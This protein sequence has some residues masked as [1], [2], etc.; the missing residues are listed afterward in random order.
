M[1]LRGIIP[2]IVTPMR[3]NE[4]VDLPRMCELIDRLLA[5][6]VHGIFVLGTT[7]EFY[8]LDAD[9]KRQV[10][11]TAVRHVNK[12][13]PVFAG[14][15]AETTRETVRITR[16]AEEEGADAVAVI[17][18]YFVQPSQAEMIDH[19][20][21]V[22]ESTKLPVLLY[23]N[24]GMAGGVRMEVGTVAQLAQVP[25]IIGMK[26]SAGDLQTLIEFIRATPPTFTV[27]QGRDTLI[28][29][30]LQFGAKGAV[31]GCS[32]IVPKLCVSIYEAH[33]RGDHAGARAA[34][35]KLSPV[36]IA[37]AAGTAPGGIKAAMN[38]LGVACGPNRS[39]IAPLSPD[40]RQKILDVLEPLR[41]YV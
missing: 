30:A 15:G 34:Q 31:P 4:E 23:H 9:E 39:P 35:L 11:S 29:P 19:F 41:E 13:V 7:G 8:A 38:A 6:G 10:I 14:T 32:N 3:S 12:R 26:D 28:E 24:P 22:A 2:P 27:F 33:V 40:Q 1:Q 20:R 25:N 21:R 37:G 17:T 36:R 16:I 18:P 5:A